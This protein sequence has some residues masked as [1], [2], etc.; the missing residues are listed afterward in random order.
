MATIVSA[1]IPAQEFALYSTLSALPGVEFET[2]QI[3]ETGEDIVMPLMWARGADH[4]ALEGAIEEDPSVDN[5]SKLAEFDEEILYQMDWIDQVQLVIQM[6]TNARATIMDARS[7]DERW[8]LRIMYPDRES[9]SATHD[10]CKSND[11]TFDV[12]SIH[13]MEGEPAQLYGLTDEQYRALVLACQRGYYDVPKKVELNELADE[14][15][16][17]HQALS[18]RLR[19]GNRALIRSSL[20]IGDQPEQESVTRS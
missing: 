11:L 6:V 10:F 15:D 13:D 14:L 7:T 18:E 8:Q 1:S 19:R 4:E 17:S 5:L 16:L 12:R 2:E 9:L 3:V 20:R